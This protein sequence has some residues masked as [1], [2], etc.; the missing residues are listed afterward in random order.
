MLK[1]TNILL[2]MK[3]AS[4]QHQVYASVTKANLWGYTAQKMI[5][6]LRIR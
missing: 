1:L 6:I 4:P 3:V 5:R 2:M